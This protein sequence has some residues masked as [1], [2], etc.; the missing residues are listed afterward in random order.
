M[1]FCTGVLGITLIITNTIFFFFFFG[2]HV[3]LF[4][5]TL[6]GILGPIL[7]YY[8]YFLRTV[9]YVLWKIVQTFLV[10]L[11]RVISLF[12]SI[13]W[14]SLWGIFRLVLDNVYLILHK[15][16]M[17]SHEALYRCS[18]YDYDGLHTKNCFLYHVPRSLFSHIFLYF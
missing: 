6:C 15:F 5:G 14:P 10:F 9:Q 12:F 1:K 11:L 4:R 7:A 2:H 3:P 13:S 18:W 16:S 8:V 17:F